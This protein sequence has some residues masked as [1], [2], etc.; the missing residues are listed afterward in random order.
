MSG[1]KIMAE[2]AYPI[3]PEIL[4]G[5]C[6]LVMNLTGEDYA[7]F[8]MDE[9]MRIIKGLKKLSGSARFDLIN[10]MVDCTGAER[11]ILIGD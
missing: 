9:G 4:S 10:H 7:T 6:K 11:E 8:S 5:L 3:K 1:I 2:A